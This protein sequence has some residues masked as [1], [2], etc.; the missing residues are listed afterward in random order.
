MRIYGSI[1]GFS[2]EP[3][4]EEKNEAAESNKRFLVFMQMPIWFNYITTPN[5]AWNG[6]GI[7]AQIET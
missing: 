5:K 3:R 1:F 2:A 6:I 7:Y 4:G